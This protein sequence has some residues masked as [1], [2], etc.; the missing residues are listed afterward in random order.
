MPEAVFVKEE[1]T[2]HSIC[3]CDYCAKHWDNHA[4]VP[5]S[6]DASGNGKIDTFDDL[7]YEANKKGAPVS[8][9][10]AGADYGRQAWLQE[11]GIELPGMLEKLVLAKARMHSV[12]V[13]ITANGRE[14]HA[15]RLTGHVLIFPHDVEVDDTTSMSAVKLRAAIRCVGVRFVGPE[16]SKTKLEAAA[17]QVRDLHLRPMVLYNY[18]KLRHELQGDE[19]P[20]PIETV[21]GWVQEEETVQAM[22]VANGIHIT[23]LR[24]EEALAASDV[25]NVRLGA[26][27]EVRAEVAKGDAPEENSEGREASQ[28]D[29]QADRRE[30]LLQSCAKLLADDRDEEI[31][32]ND[33]GGQ[34]PEPHLDVSGVMKA[35]VQG[36]GGVIEGVAKACEK[37]NTED[38]GDDADDMIADAG[39]KVQVDGGITMKR[40]ADPLDDY[41]GH[42]STLYDAFWPLFLL[43]RGLRQ[44]TSLPAPKYRHL[45]TYYDN[46]FAQDMGLL[47]SL[48]NTR[49]RHEVNKAVSAKVITSGSAFEKCNEAIND[50]A[51]DELPQGAQND[52]KGKEAQDLL[53]RVLPFLNISGR[54]VP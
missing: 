21:R 40:A 46:R 51:F 22:P 17:L 47:F 14:T 44:G 31:L 19:E 28:G 42:S 54:Q 9:I 3:V 52:P 29:D 36:M 6:V 37:A 2:I 10:A 38:A 50:P 1:S 35:P 15:E 16:G 12:I 45:M 34:E 4:A 18:M 26:S 53:K 20:P 39:K 25:A 48:A 27:D 30:H 23:D 43:R 7:Y 5:R 32:N 33:D 13:K 24:I 41:N 11:R 8:A 49:M